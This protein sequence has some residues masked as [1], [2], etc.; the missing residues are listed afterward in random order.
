MMHS[1][2]LVSLVRALATTALWTAGCADTGAH[3]TF[4]A[5]SGPRAAASFRV[6]LASPE[7]VPSIQNQRIALGDNAEQTVSYYLQRTVAGASSSDAVDKVDGFTVR[8]APEADFADTEFI[9]FVLMYDDANQIVGIGT[10]RAGDTPAP[11]PILVVRDE[12]DKYT[13]DVEAVTQVDDKAAPAPGQ[14]QV[15]ECVHDDQSTFTSGIVWRPLGGGEL[16]I[17]L[18]DDGGTDATGRELDLDCDGHVVK[19]DNSRP[20]CDDTR[21]WFHRDAE[22]ICD[23]YDTN[24]DGF[25][26]L[27]TS[28]TTSSTDQCLNP[29]TQ[30]P[31]PGVELCDDT[32][33]EPQGCHATASCQCQAGTAGCVACQ[34][35][36]LA[37][38]TTGFVRP[39]QPAIG[40]MS[41]Y[42]KCSAAAPCDVEFVGASNGW[43]FEISATTAGPFGTRAF[44]V[45]DTFLIKA[46]HPDDSTYEQQLGN[47]FLLT[48][49]NLAFI[50]PAATVYFP[51]ALRIAEGGAAAMCDASPVLTCYP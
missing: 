25:Q 11:S 32:T 18:P 13:L 49:I 48:D 45:K 44:G 47:T 16:R 28:C 14:V 4:S 40:V 17:L 3:L 43:K 20:D 51:V 23:G 10:Y 7:T 42:G 39:C 38:A 2:S 15:V 9:P 6:L 36:Y 8:I 46:K 34:M 41:T 26:T 1:R 5:P 19:P 29:T 12:I 27:A 22:D 37:G 24:C 21:N 35:P 31:V 30:M 50:T 33:G